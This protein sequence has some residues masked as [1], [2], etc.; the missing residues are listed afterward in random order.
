MEKP[1]K[2][3][4]KEDFKKSVKAAGLEFREE[5]M[6]GNY[7]NPLVGLASRGR[8][9]KLIRVM[10]KD[11]LKGKS[12]LDVGC[13]AGYVSL[14]IAEKG[15]NVF[16]FDIIHAALVAF[17]KKREGRTAKVFLAAAQK[18]P[19]KGGSFDAVVC[20]EVLEHMPHREK[21]IAEM[22]RVLKKG[23]RL[24]ITFP[25][26]KLRKPLYP[27]ARL[28]G[29]N[30]SVEDEVT[31]FDYKFEDILAICRRHFRIER[32]YSWPF[33]YPVTRFVI[34]RKVK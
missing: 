1:G 29:V 19:L 14:R 3:G 20:T 31:L 34:A 30:T 22:A 23:G 8:V 6:D 7:S 2:R 13:E 28:F 26:E 18:M 33:F 24:Y 17:R 4:M 25:N 15:A 9:D 16:S 27:L 32:K 12:V 10:E 21:G 5:P 11:G